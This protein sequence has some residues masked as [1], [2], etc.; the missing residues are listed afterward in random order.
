MNSFPKKLGASK[1]N[2]IVQPEVP[3]YPAIS[4]LDVFSSKHSTESHVAGVHSHFVELGDGV[5]H[6][7]N[8]QCMLTLRFFSVN[9]YIDL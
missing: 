9:F 1:K 5:A 4:S 3:E 8:Q 2:W 6:I 7:H